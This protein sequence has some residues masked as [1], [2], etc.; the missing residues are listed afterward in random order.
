MFRSRSFIILTHSIGWLLFTS[1]PLFFLTHEGSS[2]FTT[3]YRKFAFKGFELD[4][5]DYLLKPIWFERFSKAVRNVV[6]Y[7][8][9][10]EGT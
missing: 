4:A 1:L 2:T 5:L 6:R 10:E 7:N 8:D 9:H 3:A